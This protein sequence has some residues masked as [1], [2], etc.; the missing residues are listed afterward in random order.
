MKKLFLCC[1]LILGQQ[2]WC[3]NIL[4]APKKKESVSKMKEQLAQDFE[5]VMQL[6]TRSIRDLTG[7]MDEIVL[8]VK[9]LAGQQQGVLA[10]SDKKVLQSYQ[11]KVNELKQVLENL[12]KN[13]N[14]H[15]DL[16]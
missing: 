11:E 12:S 10:S 13:C 6:S 8:G 3:E 5:Y 16:S 15:V 7:L 2:V 4:A 9:Q 1:V 14:L